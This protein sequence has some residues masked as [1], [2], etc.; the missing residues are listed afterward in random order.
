M[1]ITFA[2][3]VRM[4]ANLL[5]TA[6][7]ARAILSWFVRDTYSPIG[8]IYGLLIRFTEPMVEPC[9]N[10]LSR[11]NTG[12]FDFSLVL[13]MIFIEIIANLAIR[14]FMFM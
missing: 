3:A 9:R 4:F 7:C 14:I 11:F 13:A 8:K 12:M 2:Y 10:L 6:L 5:V 1:G